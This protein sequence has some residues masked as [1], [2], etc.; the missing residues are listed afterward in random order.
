MVRRRQLKWDA[1]ATEWRSDVESA[2]IKWPAAGWCSC[3][4][5]DFLFA[6]W[7][8]VI[9]WLDDGETSPSDKAFDKLE[10]LV[11][12]WINVSMMT[13]EPW[14][15]NAGKASL[16]PASFEGDRDDRWKRLIH[17]LARMAKSLYTPRHGTDPAIEHP[18]ISQYRAL[19]WITQ[20]AVFLM[21]ETIGTSLK[22]TLDKHL[23]QP[24][25]PDDELWAL[26]E[27]CKDRHTVIQNHRAMK[28]AHLKARGMHSLVGR[29]CSAPLPSFFN[30][31][32]NQKN[33]FQPEVARIELLAKE[34]KDHPQTA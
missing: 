30:V 13:L 31:V 12:G 11:F 7:N 3:R 10:K 9:N 33:I 17:N 4:E 25:A 29:L 1:P 19:D 23:I 2:R 21:P 15:T 16:W 28:L 22:A 8:R 34:T 5:F 20:W 24:K 32:E 14:E 18:H 27:F 6:H 26:Y